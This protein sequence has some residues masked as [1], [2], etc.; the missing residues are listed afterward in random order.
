VSDGYRRAAHQVL[1]DKAAFKH[2]HIPLLEHGSGRGKHAHG[3]SDYPAPRRSSA[4]ATAW[5]AP[6]PPLLPFPRGSLG[7]WRSWS[8]PLLH[9]VAAVL[10]EPGQEQALK[11]RSHQAVR[12]A[13]GQCPSTVSGDVKRETNSRVRPHRW[14]SDSSGEVRSFA[15]VRPSRVSGSLPPS[16][17]E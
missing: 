7:H 14:K 1:E 11:A 12:A 15:G 10:E 16:S 9:P 5:T 2:I 4:P 6:V 3:E 13:R 8:L 17:D